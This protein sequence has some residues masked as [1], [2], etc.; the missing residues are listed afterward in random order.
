MGWSLGFIENGT[1]EV[2]DATRFFYNIINCYTHHII[3]DCVT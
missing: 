2:A 3:T 1:E